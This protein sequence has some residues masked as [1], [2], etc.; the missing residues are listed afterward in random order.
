MA[1]VPQKCEGAASLDGDVV[2][3]GSPGT[4][5]SLTLGR[6]S[7]ALRIPMKAGGR[8]SADIGMESRFIVICRD[9]DVNM[10]KTLARVRAPEPKWLLTSGVW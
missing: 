1:A 9:D 10:D 3:L 7:F 2:A 8:P 6:G 5:Q 4:A